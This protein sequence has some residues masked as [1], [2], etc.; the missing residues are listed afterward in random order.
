MRA[1]QSVLSSLL[2][3][4]P[5]RWFCPPLQATDEFPRSKCCLGSQPFYSEKRSQSEKELKKEKDFSCVVLSFFSNGNY[6]SLPLGV[7]V[8]NRGF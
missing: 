3:M 4:W 6:R 2:L 1:C 5:C 7:G 8:S